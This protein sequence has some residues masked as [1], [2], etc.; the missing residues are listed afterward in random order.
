[1]RPS[2][3]FSWF[4]WPAALFLA[5]V[6]PPARGAEPADTV[7]NEDTPCEKRF[8]WCD[9]KSSP[10]SKDE[11]TTRGAGDGG[12]PPFPD[13]PL[14]ALEFSLGPSQVVQG[15]GALLGGQVSL[16]ALWRV[17]GRHQVGLML[18]GSVANGSESGGHASLG[19]VGYRY[20]PSDG[21]HF[22]LLPVVT[23]AQVADGVHGEDAVGHIPGEPRYVQRTW[24]APKLRAGFGWTTNGVRIGVAFE[25][26]IDVSSFLLGV[27]LYV[28]GVP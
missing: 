18:E 4:I 25:M 14:P 8:P 13:L 12:A 11:K 24:I 15:P 20:A 5:T 10:P 26:I 27:S 28:G 23:W 3:F 22:D 21:S 17:S 16:R 1:M 6:S 19:V 9:A 2:P 7:K